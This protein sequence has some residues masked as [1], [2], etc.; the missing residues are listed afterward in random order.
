M[1]GYEGGACGLLSECGVEGPGWK[2][3]PT[4]TG[5]LL[6]SSLSINFQ[7]IKPQVI[8]TDLISQSHRYFKMADK[9]TSC[10][11]SLLIS[12]EASD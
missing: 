12:T 4:M 9:G 10:L 1:Q 5:A 11:F 7:R 6:L 2:C 8:L 3:C